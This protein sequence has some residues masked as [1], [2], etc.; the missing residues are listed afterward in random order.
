MKNTIC[1]NNNSYVTD[2]SNSHEYKPYTR[3]GHNKYL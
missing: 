1:E 2:V 3:S